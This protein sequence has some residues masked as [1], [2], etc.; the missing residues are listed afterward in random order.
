MNENANPA[1]P[2]SR[3]RSFGAIEASVLILLFTIAN[4][5]APW[6]VYSVVGVVAGIT[7][8][9]A[10][11]MKAILASIGATAVTLII[12]A[13][14]GG[15]VTGVASLTSALAAIGPGVASFAVTFG[16]SLIL[17]TVGAFLGTSL[18]KALAEMLFEDGSIGS[19]V[20]SQDNL[21]SFTTNP[22]DS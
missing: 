8:K 9:K 18:R 14:G 17:A 3:R 7:L 12:N 13:I 4:I 1:P 6:Y 11:S 20:D 15:D 16:A 22:V 19:N 21:G 10:P 5:Y 2:K